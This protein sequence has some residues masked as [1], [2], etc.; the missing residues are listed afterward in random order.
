MVAKTAGSFLGGLFN[1]PGALIGLIALGGLF[2]FRDKISDFFQKGFDS[3]GKIDIDLPDFPE[4]NFPSFPE[5]NFPEFPDFSNIFE[6]Q[7]TILQTF[8][9]SLGQIGG[10]YC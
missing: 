4:I 6:T 5:I 8:L 3:F 10:G 7:N 9:D 2:I 1:N